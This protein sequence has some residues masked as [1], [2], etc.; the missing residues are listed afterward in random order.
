[1]APAI[2]VFTL[3]LATSFSACSES[4]GCSTIADHYRL[5][6]STTIPTRDDRRESCFKRFG[7]AGELTQDNIIFLEGELMPCQYV[8]FDLETT[9]LSPLVERIVEIGAVR[10]TEAGEE[11]GRFEQLINP[12]RPI[13]A[14]AQAVHGLTE[15]DLANAPL[16][17]EVLP[18]FLQF[19]NEPE[20]TALIAHNATFD[21][22]FLGRELCRAR[23]GIP[24][25]R[26][27]DTLALS[28]RVH[29][30]L[31]SHRLDGL[32]DFYGLDSDV[33]HR[34]LADSLR[35]KSL[36]LKLQG[37]STLPAHLVSYAI[38]DPGQ[39][40]PAPH[41]W[42]V[43]NQAADLGWTVRIE[44]EG[45]TRGA[46]PRTITPRRFLQKGGVSY[47]LAY[48]HLDDCEKSFRLDRIRTCEL[49]RKASPAD[50]CVEQQE[51]K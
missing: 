24:T 27:F 14:G 26:V 40:T 5:S 13:S 20:T 7:P 50:R 42:D 8:A 23:L 17:E 28:R 21:A 9:G 46:S 44:Y 45:G 6:H 35:V 11:T 2:G 38:H 34:A 43:L 51:L 16:A 4:T 33:K 37:P 12:K 36:W 32:A 10:F 19:I 18:L 25:H 49:Q 48:C 15:S 3:V 1:M 47:I 29:P 41:G 22:G 39:G 30:E 31:R